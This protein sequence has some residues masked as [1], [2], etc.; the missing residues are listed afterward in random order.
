LPSE[1]EAAYYRVHEG[2]SGWLGLRFNKC[3]KLPESWRRTMEKM[4]NPKPPRMT[5]WEFMNP[6]PMTHHHGGYC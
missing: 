6:S 5:F 1:F 4:K 2:R 3:K